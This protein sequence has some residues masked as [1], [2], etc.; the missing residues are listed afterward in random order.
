[1]YIKKPLKVLWL[2]TEITKNY[3]QLM[4]CIKTINKQ[5]NQTVRPQFFWKY[6][7]IIHVF[8]YKIKSWF[9]NSI[10]IFLKYSFFFDQFS[11]LLR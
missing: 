2:Q 7:T 9:S 10:K 6:Q 3:K 4:L 11:N 5:K 1:M 8:R